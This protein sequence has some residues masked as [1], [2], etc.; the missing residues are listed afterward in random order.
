MAAQVNQAALEGNEITDGRCASGPSVTSAQTCSTI[1][2][3]R[4]SN[5]GD[6][7]AAHGP[8]PRDDGNYTRG[9]VW[10]FSEF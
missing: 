8:R 1:A 9:R 4:A 10:R 5:T 2:W 7:P 6:G 3:A